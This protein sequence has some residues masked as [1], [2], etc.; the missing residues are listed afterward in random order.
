MLKI[1]YG[2]ASFDNLRNRNDLYIDKTHFI[3][4]M[5]NHTKF[6]FIR[7]RRFGKSLWLSVLHA[8]Y[9][10]NK[11]DKFD[12]LF[13][14][15]Y[16]QKS[17]T[18]YKNS[19]LILRFDFSGLNTENEQSLKSDF[20]FRVRRQ[21]ISFFQYYKNFFDN[22]FLENIEKEFE[23]ISASQLI[24]MVK[25]KANLIQKKVYVLIDEYDHYANKL[26]SE[27]REAFVRNIVSKTG[28][29]REFYEQMKI[30]SGE[31]VFERFFITGVSPIMLDELSSGF[32]IL[33]D[34]TIDPHF[35]EMIGFTLDE[36]KSLLEKVK[37]ERYIH[38]TKEEVLQDLIQYYNGYC[39]SDAANTKLF[40]SDMVLYFMEKFSRIGYPKELLDENV[41]TDYNKLSGLIVGTS[42]KDKLQSIIEEINLNDTLILDLSKRF[43]FTQRFGDSE[44]KSLL[45]YLGLLTFS[46]PGEMKIPNYVIRTLYW[47]YLHKYLEEERNI[48]FDVTLLG[49]A[50]KDMAKRGDASGLKILATDFFQNKLSGYDFS[51]L[52]EKHVKFIFVSYFTLSKLYNIISEREL[53]GMKRIDLLFEAHPAYYDY[54]FYNFILEFKYIRKKDSE[55]VATQK[56][57]E[58]IEQARD[59]YE[60]YKRDFKQFGRELRSIALIVNH[61]RE[62]ELIEV[63]GFGECNRPQPMG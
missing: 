10:T 50:I 49:R 46:E 38:K 20:T 8:Y 30:A 31:G 17:P 28:F 63:C 45:F 25:E 15:L 32:N 18:D 55:E 21:A 11:A 42:G 56:R 16:I 60:I 54:V 23:S 22:S 35:N 2:E 26:A 58:A 34:M 37:A 9:D 62:V 59:Y 29:V 33:S 53:S 12:K 13:D 57:K 7:P 41:K 44:L 48:E 61:S 40:N 47:E 36:V 1:A 39:F 27:G 4:L 52:T 5:E 24:S 3:P 19:Y 6:F 51:G 14:E 43:N